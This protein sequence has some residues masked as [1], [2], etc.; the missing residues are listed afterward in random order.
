MPPVAQSVLIT[1]ADPSADENAALLAAELKALRPQLRLRGV[2]GEAMKRAGVEL[3]ADTVTNAAMGVGAVGR[4]A[5]V[6]KLLGRVRLE[7]QKERPGLMICIDS[8]SMNV[9]FARLGREMGIPVL[10]YVAPQTWASREG[11]V[12]K[13]REVVTK[14]ACIL[15]FEEAYFRQFGID[16]DFVGHPLW[17]RI[18]VRSRPEE[19]PPAV[20]VLPGSRKGVTRANW[21]RLV[22][23]M[24]TIR[25]AVP[26]VTFRVAVTRNARAIIGEAPPFE[27]VTFGE[28][29]DILPGCSLALC[30]SGTAALHVAA[31]GVPL[32]VVYYGNPLLWHLLG[33][34]VVRTRTYSLVNLLSGARDQITYGQHI[35]PEYIPWYGST[36]PVA[37]HAIRLLTKKGELGKMKADIARTIAPLAQGGASRRTAEIAVQM[38]SQKK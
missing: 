18:D 1:V 37:Q 15:P 34:W 6:S 5:E 22:E 4:V 16:A 17:D 23:V 24:R 21:P 33:R 38:L 29:D 8:W 10:Y 3:F 32:I 13:M 31:H 14:L 35:V 12:K 30:V 7:V 26:G 36:L 28:I 19:V 25:A 27:G 20:A 2:G 9:H 11:R